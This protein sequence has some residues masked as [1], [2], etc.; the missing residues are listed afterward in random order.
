MKASTKIGVL[1]LATT[2]NLSF[3]KETKLTTDMQ[4]ASY[5]IGQQ[6]GV[7]PTLQQAWG[8]IVQNDLQPVHVH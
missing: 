1:A 4:K 3:A 8:A 6:I 2:A 7:A 5:A